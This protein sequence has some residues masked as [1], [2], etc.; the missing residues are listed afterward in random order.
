[1]SGQ[2]VDPRAS[3]RAYLEASSSDNTRRAYKSDWA[4]FTAWCEGAGESSLPATPI[5]VATYIAQLAD[6]GVKASTIQRRLAAI[7][8]V[9]V[10][11][12]AEPPTNAEGVKATMRGIRRAKGTR[13]N[14][15]APATAEILGKLQAVFPDTLTGTRDRAL[16]LLGFAAAL[17]RSELVA[18]HVSD[19][20]WR[21]KGVLLHIARSKTDQEGKGEHIPVPRGNALKPV[22]AL[23]AW[24]KAG[25]ITEGPIF[26]GI[27]RHGRIALSALSD[28]AV[29]D[30]VKKACTAAGLDA[31]VFSGH[32][33]RAG[34]VTSSLD[35]HVDLFKIMG[36]TRH[37]KVDTLK[38]YDRRESGFEDHAGEG[39][40]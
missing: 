24:L 36:I 17:R 37:V 31:S 19:V 23:D 18:L 34:F 20:T 2:L 11:A 32:S 9:H 15:K 3:V 16:V 1:M 33:L 14:K 25:R 12:G 39:F 21:R 40:L 22:D 10:A 7:R 30:I 26:R 8:A 6:R 28:R 5:S 4:D 29:A 13:P 38:G 35:H 27:D